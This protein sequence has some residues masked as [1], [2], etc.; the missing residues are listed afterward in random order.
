MPLEPAVKRG[1]EA[2]GYTTPTPIQWKAMPPLLEGRDV[3]GLAPTGTGKTLAYGIPLVQHMLMNP[4][5]IQRRQ[6][7]RGG[8]GE[9]GGRY[10]D[11]RQRLRTLVV[12]PTRELAS[13]VAEEVR[14]LTKGSLI[15]VAAVWGK[16]ALKPQRERIEAGIDVLAGTP[17]RLRELMDLDVLSLAY[18][19][20]LVIDEGDRM[21][22]MGFLPQIRAILERMPEDRQMAFF[23][24]TMPPAIEDLARAF[25][26]KPMR[27]EIGTHTRAA[28]HLGHRL[29]E[30]DDPLK[31]PLVLG[32]VV[33]ES[34]HGVLVFT[35]TRRRAGWVAAAL[36]RQGVSVGLVHGDRSQNQRLRA[37]EQFAEGKLAVIV[38]TDVAARGLHIPAI[39]TV[40]NYDLP[41]AAE[42][43]VHRVGRAGHGGGFGE[44]ITLVA[45]AETERWR[46]ISAATGTRL[47]PAELPEFEQWAR[48]QDL[49]RVERLRSAEKAERIE[50]FRDSKSSGNAPK[51]RSSGGARGGKKA[52]RS[53][54]RGGDRIGHGRRNEASRPIK[55]GQKPGSGVRKPK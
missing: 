1:L 36:R 35:R 43:W 24:A 39:Q 37:L 22:D 14:T 19:S 40:I 8:R 28:E 31:V 10:V 18:I 44:S 27:I 7:R 2:M 30:I 13:Q 42:E 32:L 41:L 34:R 54:L 49:A 55:K 15:K 11:P 45:P 46:K 17:G 53:G 21:L 9:A 33:D 50:P 3:I 25:L 29:L 48:P 51:A 26:K 5:P 38:A 12:V 52:A 16:A 23:S 4:P 6:S 47:Y 20:H